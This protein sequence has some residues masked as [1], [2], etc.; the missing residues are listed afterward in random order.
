MAL[1]DKIILT[2]CFIIYFFEWINVY[3]RGVEWTVEDSLSL[4]PQQWK[5][6]DWQRS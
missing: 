1:K 3:E 6:T 2:A 4:L 5:C